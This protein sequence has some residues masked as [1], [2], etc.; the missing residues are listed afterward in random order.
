MTTPAGKERQK[1]ISKS[2]SSLRASSLVYLVFVLF[3]FLKTIGDL[4]GR[5][6]F[7]HKIISH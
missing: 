7:E 4:C 1:F 6:H 5:W 3:C 2:V